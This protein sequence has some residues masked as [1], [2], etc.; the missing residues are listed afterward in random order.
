MSAIHTYHHYRVDLEQGPLHTGLL[1]PLCHQDSLADVFAVSLRR[2]NQPIDLTGMTVSGCMTFQS[3]RQTLPLAGEVSGSTATLT[4]TGDCYAIP[5]SFTLTIQVAS[6]DVRHTLVY[7]TGE[8]IRAASDAL[9]SSGELLPPLP[10]LLEQIA[11]MKSATVQAEN[12]AAHAQTIAADMESSLA[13][14]APVIPLEASGSAVV[15]RDAA[16]R[17]AAALVTELSSADG[18]SWIAST[19]HFTCPFS[20]TPFTRAPFSSPSTMIST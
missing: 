18:V 16:A 20:F 9:I 12:A 4:L 13:A 11:D 6:G 17:P 10:V 5:G 7:L 19:L 3:T 14:C 2:G 15:I 1:Q 8:I